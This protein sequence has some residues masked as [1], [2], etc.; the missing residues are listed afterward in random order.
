MK[1]YLRKVNKYPVSIQDIQSGSS[2]EL[3]RKWHTGIYNY[4]KICSSLGLSLKALEDQLDQDMSV[5]V[6][7]K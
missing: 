7:N 4:D 6:Y 1:G 3:S 5:F 2:A